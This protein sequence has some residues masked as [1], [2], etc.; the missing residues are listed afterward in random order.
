V[1]QRGLKE[2]GTGH[3]LDQIGQ[4]LTDKRIV[5]TQLVSQDDGFAILTQGVGGVAGGRVDRHREI[6]QSHGKL[7]CFS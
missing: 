4:V 6:T 2:H 7:L 5:E 3:V 1:D